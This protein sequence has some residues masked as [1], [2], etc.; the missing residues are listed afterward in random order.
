MS[1]TAAYGGDHLEAKK[2][3]TGQQT[4][5]SAMTSFDTLPSIGRTTCRLTALEYLHFPKRN[6]TVR[7]GGTS[8]GSVY[9]RVSTLCH[10]QM[11][12]KSIKSMFSCWQACIHIALWDIVQKFGQSVS[13]AN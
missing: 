3:K 5:V 8:D 13:S 2:R 9:S 12:F 4:K 7:L 11:N 10:I 6:S 1:L